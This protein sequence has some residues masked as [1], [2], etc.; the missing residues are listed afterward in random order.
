VIRDQTLMPGEYVAVRRTFDV[1]GHRALVGQVMAEHPEIWVIA[2][3]E[4]RIGAQ[5]QRI[6]YDAQSW[7]TNQMV[8]PRPPKITTR[9]AVQLPPPTTL[10]LSTEHKWPSRGRA[11]KKAS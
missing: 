9:Y 2:S 11:S 7:H 3:R 8:Q 4:A 6:I 10:D 1:P 5:G